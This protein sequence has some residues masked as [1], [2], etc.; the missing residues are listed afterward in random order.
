MLPPT[1]KAQSLSHS[2]SPV[3]QAAEGASTLPATHAQT[4]WSAWILFSSKTQV[5]Y[6]LL[7]WPLLGGV[8]SVLSMLSS[9]SYNHS[10]SPNNWRSQGQKSIYLC[11]LRT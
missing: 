11:I 5:K 8:T 4:Y 1:S 2:A 7:P 3:A 10:C 6:Q 9:N